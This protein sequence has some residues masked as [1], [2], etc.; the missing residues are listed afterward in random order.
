MNVSIAYINETTLNSC[1]IQI[2]IDLMVNS[3][4]WYLFV[5][6]I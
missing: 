6:E 5:F 2:K 4:A 3:T 1:N